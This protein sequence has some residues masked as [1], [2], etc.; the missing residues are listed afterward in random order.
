MHTSSIQTLILCQGFLFS[1]LRKFVFSY[2]K[3][4][5]DQASYDV[6][7]LTFWIPVHD[8]QS[9]L[10]PRSACRTSL[11]WPQTAAKTKQE[12]LNCKVHNPP[13]W[14]SASLRKG[15]N[16]SPL[17]WT[18]LHF[19]DK[20]I[21]PGKCWSQ[22]SWGVWCSTLHKAMLLWE[23]FYLHYD[24]ADFFSKSFFKRQGL[25]ANDRHWVGLVSQSCSHLHT[26]R[27]SNK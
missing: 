19:N 25:D 7:S 24:F 9:S 14:S 20:L 8:G 11:C 17:Y 1:Y 10:T 13:Q 23:G 27:H 15:C 5:C 16:P 12:I 26:C 18:N 2:N 22:Q 3:T 6:A 21:F 4:L